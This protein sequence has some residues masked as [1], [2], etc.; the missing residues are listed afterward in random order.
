MNVYRYEQSVEAVREAVRPIVFLAGPTVRGNQP[1][2]TSWRFDCVREFECQD[3]GGSL[4]VPE[5]SSKV[6][7]D[8]GKY[9]IPLW[10]FNGLKTA[11]CILFWIPRTRELIGLTTNW[12][13][14]YWIGRKVDKV[15][16]GRPDDAYR[17]RYLDIMWEAIFNER[18]IDT[19][20]INS[21]LRDTVS[22]A[23]LKARDSQ[24][25]QWFNN[26]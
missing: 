1:H 17:I 21:T 16:Y 10:E 5:F 7:S 9:W 25:V 19:P 13:L 3:F 8:K 6:E 4:I 20:V 2:L 14:G 23:I 18:G 11:D 12:E 15:V 24:R 26:G 22:A